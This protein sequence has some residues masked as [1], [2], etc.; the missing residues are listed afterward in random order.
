MAR[1]YKMAICHFVAKKFEMHNN[2]SHLR[3]DFQVLVR[4]VSGDHYTN[5]RNH[6]LSKN[7]FASPVIIVAYTALI[8]FL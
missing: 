3:Y 5:D 8:Y 1:N 7:K 4:F 2:S 6:R